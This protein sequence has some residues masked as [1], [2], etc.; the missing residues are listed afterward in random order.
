MSPTLPIT[1][2]GTLYPRFGCPVFYPFLRKYTRRQPQTAARAARLGAD[3]FGPAP[4]PTTGEGGNPFPAETIPAVDDPRLIGTVIRQSRFN[5]FA[6]RTAY[7]GGTDLTCNK[8]DEARRW[9]EGATGQTLRQQE[10]HLPDG[11]TAY[12]YWN[13]FYV[14]P[15]P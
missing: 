1:V 15:L 11:T 9:M 4:G 5:W 3:V 2:P 12:E 10:I 14:P 6:F 13:D 7:W 8:L